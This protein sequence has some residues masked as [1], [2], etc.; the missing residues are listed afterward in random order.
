[1]ASALL[2][3]IAFAAI[4]V[5]NTQ[6]AQ[7]PDS[8]ATHGTRQPTAQASSAPTSRPAAPGT[9]PATPPTTSSPHPGTAKNIEAHCRAYE[10]VKNKVTP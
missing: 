6:Q 3:G 10:R 9:A 8:D 1:M 7:G 4:G 5:V 2:G